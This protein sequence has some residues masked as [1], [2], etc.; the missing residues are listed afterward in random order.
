MCPILLPIYG[1]FAINFYGLFIAIGI[2]CALF[3]IKKDSCT[4]NLISDDQG[5]TLLTGGII[6]GIIGGRILLLFTENSP[7]SSWYDVFAFWQGGFAEQGSIIAVVLFGSI[8]LIKNKIPALPLL[9]LIGTYAPIIQGFG[10]IGCFFAG[11]C[12]GTICTLPWAFTY[13]HPASLAPLCVPL[14][15]TQLYSAALFFMLF[16]GIKSIRKYLKKPGL[17]FMLYLMGT[18]LIRFS[19][20]FWRGDSI[21]SNLFSSYQY[22]SLALFISAFIMFIILSYRKK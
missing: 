13:T 7:F 21:R 19:T 2:I 5:L 4:H 9:D 22:L 14:H 8:Y 1:P 11:C 16:F 17:Q 15:P 6:A 18:S 12:Y 20:D 3:L 10:R